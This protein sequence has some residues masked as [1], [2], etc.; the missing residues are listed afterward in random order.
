MIP[1]QLNDPG[2]NFA[3]VHRLT[4]VT[5]HM[6]FLLPGAASRGVVTR[7]AAITFLHVNRMQNCP[8][9][10]VVLRMLIINVYN[11]F[12]KKKFQKESEIGKRV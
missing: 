4:P 5:V 2:V 6:N 7:L 10:R 12:P 11:K 8:G 1:G 9:V 3:S